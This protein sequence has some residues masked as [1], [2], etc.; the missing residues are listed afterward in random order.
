MCPCRGVTLNESSKFFIFFNIFFT[1]ALFWTNNMMSLCIVCST[2]CSFQV[3]EEQ[4]I[5]SIMAESNQP[6][7]QR[8]LRGYWHGL[9][10]KKKT[11]ILSG[12]TSHGSPLLHGRCFSWHRGSHHSEELSADTAA[13]TYW[14]LRQQLRIS[15]AERELQ[16]S[17][18]LSLSPAIPLFYSLFITV[19]VLECLVLLLQRKIILDLNWALL[20]VALTDQMKDWNKNH[21]W[22]PVTFM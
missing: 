11:R 16:L 7:V 22:P 20:Y 5:S 15:A 9:N 1:F 4:F 12:L 17:L 18:S 8:H 10:K 14:F 2:H 19:C 6:S 3:H 21:M 13:N